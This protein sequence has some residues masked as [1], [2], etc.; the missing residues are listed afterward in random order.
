VEKYVSSVMNI[1]DTKLE[2]LRRW[3][4]QNRSKILTGPLKGTI[5][6]VDTFPVC[7]PQPK[8]MEERKRFFIYKPGHKTRYGYK[9]QTFVNLHGRILDV[10]AAH[11]FGSKADITLFRE[12]R[13][14]AML[15]RT[16]GA[17]APAPVDFASRIE[18]RFREG[19][20][21]ADSDTDEASAEEKSVARRKRRKKEDSGLDFKHQFAEGE[22]KTS[23]SIA[24]ISEALSQAKALGDKAYLG[25]KL[26]YVPHKKYKGKRFT[27]EKKEFN[28]LLSSKRV[29]VEN[30]NK[31]LEDWKV[32][33]A[34]YRGK[35]DP[36]AVSRIVRVVASL[37]NFLLETHP[38]RKRVKRTH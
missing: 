2:Y 38:M 37:H 20:D 32:L 14:P 31:R 23:H 29:I 1:L 30:V 13:I 34:I 25:S 15:D 12:S 24:N 26:I 10:T 7:C 17:M 16:T 9:V 8:P 35:R 36:E 28:K 3:P 19:S 5:G 22:T 21:A 11:P 33:G 6:A 18:S 4:R 27:R